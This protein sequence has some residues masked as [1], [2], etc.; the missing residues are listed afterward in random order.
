MLHTPHTPVE[1]STRLVLASALIHLA[2]VAGFLLQRGKVQ[3]APVHLPGTDRGTR[4]VLTYLPGPA[5]S[6]SAALRP[7]LP[8]RAM[9]HHAILPARPALAQVPPPH[10]GPAEA[11]Q[12]PGSGVDALGQG[13]ISIA[14]M[15]F[16][17]D[18][19]PDLSRLPH[20]SR[21]DV[22]LEAVIDATGHIAQLTVKQGLGYGIDESVAATVERWTFTPAM[23]D[24]KPVPSQQEF[25]FHYE[26]G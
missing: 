18:P 14:L 24:G 8:H 7:V 12:L 6:A 20:G 15:Q 13:D 21:G 2:V 5:P 4:L 25:H 26:H 22:V 11:Q 3:V 19:R 9:L 1:R 17:P 16:F 23:R 10:A